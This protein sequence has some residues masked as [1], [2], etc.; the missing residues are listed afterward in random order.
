MVDELHIAR[1]QYLDGSIPTGF[2]RTTIVGVNGWVPFKDRRIRIVHSA[3]WR[4]PAA[5]VSDV[6]HRRTYSPNGWGCAHRTVTAPDM[7]TPHEAAEVGQ[8]LRPAR[9]QHG[10][11]RTGGRRPRGR[12]RQ[13]HG[14]TRVESRASPGIPR[15]PL[16]TTTEAM[17]Q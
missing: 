6:G 16:L 5:E 17:R 13:G 2:Q 9:A 8:L 11:G 7:K 1:K 12:H 14:G 4:T 3:R 15:I 10:P